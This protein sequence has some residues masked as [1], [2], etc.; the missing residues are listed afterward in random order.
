[1]LIA[2]GTILFSHATN[3]CNIFRRQIQSA[4]NGGRLSFLEMQ[5]DKQPFPA[6]MM[7]LTDKKYWFAQMWPIKIDK[8]IIIGSPYTSKT[9]R[10]VIT[11]KAPDKRTNKT[12]GIG[13]QARSANQLKLHVSC[14]M[15]GPALAHGRSGSD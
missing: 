5:I 14:I 4:I 10:G 1:V 2:S 13:G 15:D 9:S 7:E 8:I 6:N 3:D 12:G 11:Q